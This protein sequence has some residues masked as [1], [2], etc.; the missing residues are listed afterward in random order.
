MAEEFLHA[1]DVGPGVEQVRGEAVAERM[2]AGLAGEP[3]HGE[4]LLQQPRDTPH[5]EPAAEFVGKHRSRCGFSTARSRGPG[6]QP[7]PDRRMRVRAHDPVTLAP[8]FAADP[9]RAV[10][11]VEITVVDRDELPHAAACGVHQL[12][13]RPVPQTAS[14]PRAR[15]REQ[16]TNLIPREKLRQLSGSARAAE[17]LGRIRPHPPLALA[18]GVETPHAGQLAGDRGRGVSG[19]VQ[20]GGKPPQDHAGGVAR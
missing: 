6:C 10:S 17:R 7:R 9:H 1:P 3:G 13:D 20:P 4:M 18:E 14:L 11:Q 5:R 12:E 2:G 16:P 8:P 19:G 15:R